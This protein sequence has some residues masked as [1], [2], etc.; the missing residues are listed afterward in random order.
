VAAQVHPRRR[1]A[2]RAPTQRTRAPNWR[3]TCS[4]PWR[5]QS[6]PTW[7]GAYRSWR[8]SGCWSRRRVAQPRPPS[9]DKKFAL[10]GSPIALIHGG[11]AYFPLSLSSLYSWFPAIPQ[12]FGLAWEGPGGCG[13]VGFY[14]L[15][16][17]S[18]QPAQDH[19][20]HR[21][22]RLSTQQP[23]A[24]AREEDDPDNTVPL[25]S[26]RQPCTCWQGGPTCRRVFS[27][28]IDWHAGHPTVQWRGQRRMLAGWP[29]GTVGRRP[30]THPGK[31]GRTPGNS[32]HTAG[33]GGGLSLFSSS[34][35]L[36]FPNSKLP[37]KFKISVWTSASNIKHKSNMNNT[38][39]T[40]NN[41]ISFLLLS[42]L[43]NEIHTTFITWDIILGVYSI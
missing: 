15:D 9:T 22:I 24:W 7:E 36:C 16:T 6:R 25:A 30:S 20:R 1:H 42:Y 10:P 40:R 26:E 39:T 14:T 2:R 4:I 3:R 31:L 19:R 18:Q 13:P 33:R 12:S 35:I 41:I 11:G 29:V 17:R 34:F 28:V 5:E 27:G 37:F 32:A 21:R 38:S 23:P 8:Y 43:G